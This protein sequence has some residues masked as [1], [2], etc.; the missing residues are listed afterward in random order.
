MPSPQQIAQLLVREHGTLFAEQAGIELADEAESLWQLL[1]MAQLLSA[2]ISS[3]A[4]LATARELWAA[5]WTSPEALRRSTWNQRVAALGRGGYRRYDFSTATRLAGDAEMLHDLWS[6]D[7]RR[8]RDETVTPARIA[9]ELQRFDGIGPV[10][11]SIFLR[12][13]QAVWPSVRP[14]ADKLVLKGAATAGLPTDAD[15][16]AALVPPED[17]ARLAAALVRVARKPSLVAGL[18]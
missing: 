7:L 11:A 18:G 1:V 3:D 13:V 14:C 9:K 8:L 5:G 6:D 12:E 17:L 15:Q 10:G 16:L 4:A 2:R